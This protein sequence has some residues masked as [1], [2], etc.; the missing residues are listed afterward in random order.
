MNNRLLS[1]TRNFIAYMPELNPISG[2]ILPSI[3]MQQLDYWFHRYPDGFWKFL[4]PCANP[5]YKEGDSWTEEI[6]MS[7]YEFRTAFDS[8]GYRHSSKSAF[9]AAPDKFLGRMYASY[10]D[11][12]ANL[13]YYIRNHALVDQ[14]LDELVARGAPTRSQPPENK[15]NVDSRSAGGVVPPSTAAS[16]RQFPVDGQYQSP[17]DAKDHA[18]TNSISPVPGGG[19]SQ[20]HELGNSNLLEMQSTTLPTT[21]NTVQNTFKQLP[22]SEPKPAALEKPS[23]RSGGSSLNE[24]QGQKLFYPLVTGKE[25]T[26]IEKIIDLCRPDTR[27]DVLDEIEGIRLA[28]GIK[29]GA[30][31]LATALVKR[32]AAGEFGLS[33]GVAVQAQR[34]RRANNELAVQAATAPVSQ[35]TMPAMTEEAIS[36]LPKHMADRARQAMAKQ[37]A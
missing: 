15:A 33:A 29:R 35:G 36:K 12:R 6:G 31:P 16:Y 25:L 8:I 20:S 10:V 23:S 1:I 27:Q 14:K 5:M 13:T 7:Q 26:A 19:N 34:E 2:G 21:D 37:A 30:V 11:K 4:E 28:G 3:L 9:L 24:N 18:T 17:V 32:V 22:Q